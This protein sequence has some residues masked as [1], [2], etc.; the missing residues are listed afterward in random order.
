MQGLLLLYEEFY[1]LQRF[2]HALPIIYLKFA[3]E[4]SKVF[5]FLCEEFYLLKCSKHTLPIVE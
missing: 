5:I 2:K 3:R 1:I 4:S